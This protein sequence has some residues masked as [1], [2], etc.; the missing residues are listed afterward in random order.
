MSLRRIQV[1]VVPA[2]R[3]LPARLVHID[4]SA[5]AISD[6]IGVDRFDDLL[7]GSTPLGMYTIYG[8]GSGGPPLNLAAG[9][10]VGAL[11]HSGPDVRRRMRGDVLV[12][13][14]DA[15]GIVDID[16]PASVLAAAASAGV[17]IVAG[18]VLLRPADPSA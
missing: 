13:G 1:L 3:E 16:V 14:L 2:E 5:A 8:S 15:S 17:P 18:G 10:L 11:G 12:S 9:A 4:D 6:A 7:V